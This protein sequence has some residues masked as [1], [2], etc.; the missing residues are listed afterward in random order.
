M[1]ES[2]ST[3]TAKQI[4][5]ESASLNGRI[6]SWSQDHSSAAVE[7]EIAFKDRATVAAS[8]CPSCFTISSKGISR[9]TLTRVWAV[10]QR[11]RAARS[12]W[13][14][15]I[16][17]QSRDKVKTVSDA[18]LKVTNLFP[19]ILQDAPD[20]LESIDLT[21]VSA[22]AHLERGDR[23][24]TPSHQMKR[25]ERVTGTRLRTGQPSAVRAPLA[26]WRCNSAKPH[27][28]NGAIEFSDF[29]FSNC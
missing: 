23:V 4:I 11:G 18:N 25:L 27:S 7:L 17:P 5:G 9:L 15:G 3:Q 26:A 1:L 10:N 6:S 14:D 8:G 2:N 20:L 16:R 28:S 12:S 29:R 24:R 13:S 22:Y 19:K 21:P